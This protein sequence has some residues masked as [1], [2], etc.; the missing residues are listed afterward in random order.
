MIKRLK[1]AY[2]DATQ[3]WY[4]DNYSALGT[5]DNIGLYFNS[6]KHFRPGYGCYPEPSKSVQIVH[7]NN[8][9]S[10]KDFC[11]RHG[12]KVFTGTFYLGSF[13]G[14]EESKCEWLKYW[15]LAWE[16]FFRAIVKTESKCSQ[17]SY[18]VVVHAIQ[19]EWIFLQRVM[20]DTGYAF[21]GMETLPQ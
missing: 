20:K 11:L 9:A 15:T 1:A 14:D 16:K 18:A 8:L 5:F 19:P 2:P 21:V 10:W 3:P 4:A 17:E 6:L 12:F 13:I 7:P